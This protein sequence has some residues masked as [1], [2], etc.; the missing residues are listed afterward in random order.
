MKIKFGTSGWRAVIADDFTFSNVRVVVQ[1]IADYIKREGT[2]IKPVVVGSDTRF[3]SEAFIRIGIEVLAGNGIETIECPVGVPT[4]VI[5]YVVIKHHC[6]G[7]INFTASHNPPVYQGIK[8]TP[9]W[10]GPALPETTQQVESNCQKIFSS[11]M[12]PKTIPYEKALKEKLVRRINPK[13]SYLKEMQKM[14]K[15]SVMRKAHLKVGVDLLYGAG[16]GYLDE[17][18]Q[19]SGC[20]IFPV[21]DKRDV[22]FGG[23]SPDTSFE[24]LKELTGLIR[25]RTLDMGVC[26]DGDGDRFGII[27][28]DGTYITPNQVLPL[29]LYH[30]VETRKWKG[31]VA[32]SVMT[33]HFLDAVAKHYGIKVL[34]TPVGFKYISQAIRENDFI[35]GGEESGGLTIKGHV[36]EKDGILACLLM[37]ELKAFEKKPFAK[38]LDNLQKKVGYFYS[39]RINI[40]LDEKTMERFAERMNSEPP[41]RI[42]GFSTIRI[43]TVDGWKYLFKENAWM[44]IRL[45]GTEP[46]VRLYVEADSSKNMERL[47]ASGK[48]IIMGRI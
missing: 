40:S 34:E 25:K 13:P 30:L 10:G 6:S 2:P 8:F 3:L 1:A 27:D 17:A 32:R 11:P 12:Q 39:E 29:L 28:A 36:P 46:V 23:S 33:S 14:I 45:S 21:H 42:D 19:D 22:L 5:S 35:I 47:I 9:S 15:R 7:G 20:I 31:I 48:K 44:G 4:P 18:L 26:T 43:L 16:R 37:V 41:I 24:N 38:I